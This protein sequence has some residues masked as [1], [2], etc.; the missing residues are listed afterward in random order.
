MNIEQIDTEKLDYTTFALTLSQLGEADRHRTVERIQSLLSQKPSGPVS[1][2]DA[3]LADG[4]EEIVAFRSDIA[5]Q[6]LRELVK[7][8][9]IDRMIFED[10]SLP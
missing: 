8:G 10:A 2:Q 3:K 5:A 7:A 6:V 9:K 1:F 4:C